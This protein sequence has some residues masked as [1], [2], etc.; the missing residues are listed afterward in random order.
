MNIRTY[1]ELIT[2]DTFIGRYNYLKLN[3]SVCNETFGYDR[4]IN[5]KFY[6]SQEWK[7]IRNY[8]ILRDN[9]CDLGVEGRDIVD[10]IIIHHM[11]P[12]SKKDIIDR[13]DILLNPEY[14]I[15]VSRNTHNAIHYGDE[16]ILLGD[17]I[18]K[19]HKD[20]TLLWNRTMNKPYN[21]T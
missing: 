17:N 15:C 1:Q 12:V 20:D 7:R 6:K 14:M 18:V 19:R 16:S 3:G 11:N 5:Q 9:G 8:V 4:Y 10:S 2:I 21:E 13:T